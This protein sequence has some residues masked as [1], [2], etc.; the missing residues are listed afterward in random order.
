MQV[1]IDQAAF[2]LEAIPIGGTYTGA[3]VTDVTFNPI[4]ASAGLH[5]IIYHYTDESGC[6]SSCTFTIEVLPLPLLTCPDDMQVCIDQE[7]FNLEA[8]PIGGSFTGAGVTGT[9]F[10]PAE[11]GTG[12]HQITYHYTD[13]SGCTSSCTF[14]IEVL[15]LPLLSCP[16]DVQVCID[17][18]AFQM[19]AIPIGGS[20]TGAGVTGTTFNP[21][22]AGTGI[23]HITYQF[24]DETGCTSSCTFTIEVLALPVLS[25]PDDI[26]YNISDGPLVLTG[27]QPEG[28]NYEGE[29]V[30]Q[31]IFYPSTLESGTYTI[32]YSFEME[33]GNFNCFFNIHLFDDTIVVVPGD[34][35]C[36]GD[37]DI[38]DVVAIINQ[39]L[40]LEP[41]PF[42][43]ANADINQDGIVDILDAVAIINLILD[44]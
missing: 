26:E 29:G 41:E 5:H 25:C 2:Q 22:E 20:F 24:T 15:P 36:D 28:G 3:G 10:N 8:I 12:I 32:T 33:C 44:Q 19:E 31:G 9:T 43:E 18:A 42:C 27:A 1:C 23:H 4:M 34:A 40:D 39:I 11:A 6:T 7:A 38:L 21:A 37:V 13:E 30:S 17:Q 35:N 16:D 14:T